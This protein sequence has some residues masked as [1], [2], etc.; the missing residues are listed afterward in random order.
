[1]S[2]TASSELTAG[3]THVG[4]NRRK[5][6]SQRNLRH[7]DDDRLDYDLL[8]GGTG[9]DDLFGLDAGQTLVDQDGTD[10]GDNGTTASV[11]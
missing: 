3:G 9:D 1:M 10:A 7:A 11:S 6:A 4:G 5:G 2:A 8:T